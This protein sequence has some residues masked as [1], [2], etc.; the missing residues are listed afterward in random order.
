MEDEGLLP[1]Q[2]VFIGN[3]VPVCRC[4]VE[5][6]A[7]WYELRDLGQ[8]APCGSTSATLTRV[9]AG[10]PSRSQGRTTAGPQ[11]VPTKVILGM[12]VGTFWGRE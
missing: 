1:A 5:K 2:H 6:T 10:T 11:S 7:I 12:E 9:L 4:Q 3:G 8:N